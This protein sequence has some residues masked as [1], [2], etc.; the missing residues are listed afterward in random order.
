MNRVPARGFQTAATRAVNWIGNVSVSD[1]VQMNNDTEWENALASAASKVE[2]Q[3][4]KVVDAKI[5]GALAHTSAKDKEEKEKIVTV[6]FY[7][8]GGTRLL[9]SH[10]RRDGSYK[11]WESRAGK[12]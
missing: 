3:N 11:S 12:R 1:V 9:S 6:G 2:A 5:Q 4:P 10:V 8:A 7:S